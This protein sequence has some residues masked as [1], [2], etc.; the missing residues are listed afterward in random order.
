[1]DNDTLT[2]F[3]KSSKGTGDNV[4]L[5]SLVQTPVKKKESVDPLAESREFLRELNLLLEKYKIN[6]EQVILLLQ[7]D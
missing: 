3:S 2:V 7:K 5:A 4:D 1:M 6:K